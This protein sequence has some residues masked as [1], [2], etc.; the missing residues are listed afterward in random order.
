[1][2]TDRKAKGFFS[3][4]RGA[5]RSAAA[6]GLNSTIAHLVMARGTGPDNRTTQWSVNAIEKYT[7]ISRPNA[8]TAV[9]DLLDRGIWKKTRDGTHPVYEAAPGNE[10]PGGPFTRLEQATIS[11]I[12]EG[13][14]V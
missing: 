7:G 8:K 4:D 10:I 9:A 11:A 3:I 2:A 12:R 5:F 6:G 14:V 1:M 13:N